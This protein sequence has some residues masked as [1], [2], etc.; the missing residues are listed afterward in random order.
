MVPAEMPSLDTISTSTLDLP[1]TIPEEDS[2]CAP[3]WW[4]AS[5]VARSLCAGGGEE[6]GRS[7]E[8]ASP[9]GRYPTD[10]LARLLRTLAAEMILVSR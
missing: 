6:F 9:N 7:I 3:T 5:A 10:F 1:P 2:D 4:D 8:R